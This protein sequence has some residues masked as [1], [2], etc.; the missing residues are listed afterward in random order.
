MKTITTILLMAMAFPALSQ[1]STNQKDFLI[2]LKKAIWF[3]PGETYPRP[4][5]IKKD[6]RLGRQSRFHFKSVL[7][8][9]I[10]KRNTGINQVL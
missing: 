3:Y 6:I 4:A 7:A 1:D 5:T 9:I 2:T 10:S 8:M